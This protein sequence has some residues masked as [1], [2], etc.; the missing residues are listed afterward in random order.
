M[1]WG[2]QVLQKI[3]QEV[4]VSEN[5]IIVAEK[6]SSMAKLYK[7]SNWQK[8][9][10]D[11]AWRSLLLSQHHDCWIVPYNGKLGH[12]WADNVVK[13]TT[14]TNQNSDSVIKSSISQLIKG[15]ANESAEKYIRVFNTVWIHRS[16]W[17]ELSLPESWKEVKIVD[18]NNKEIASQVAGRVDGFNNSGSDSKE[19]LFKAAVPALGYNTY[20]LVRQSPAITKMGAGVAVLSNGNYKIETDLY[21]IIINPLHLQ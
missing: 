10:L 20:R 15:V 13:W 14:N 16:E 7:E 12:T 17:V 19:I 6:L 18:I 5:K 21:T 8:E 1:V 4:R 11:K 2:A 9:L 3:A